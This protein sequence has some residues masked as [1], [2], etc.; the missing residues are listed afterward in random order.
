MNVG[1]LHGYRIETIDALRFWSSDHRCNRAKAVIAFSKNLK[2]ANDNLRRM[3]YRNMYRKKALAALGVY[4]NQPR[5][6]SIP[7]STCKDRWW[8][9]MFKHQGKGDF[10]KWKITNDIDGHWARSYFNNGDYIYIGPYGTV[11]GKAPLTP[12]HIYQYQGVHVSGVPF[13]NVTP[14]LVDMG[15][16]D[17]EDEL[18]SLYGSSEVKEFYEWFDPG[19]RSSSV[20]W[21]ES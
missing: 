21:K 3:G 1:Y 7:F 16:Y 4:V 5:M 18:Y 19:R 17:P 2:E 14:D 12:G 10:V 13:N 8:D 11:D 20:S 9:C 6:N 15:A